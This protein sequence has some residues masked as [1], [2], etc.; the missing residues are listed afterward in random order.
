MKDYP[1][2][3][4]GGAWRR[5]ARAG[6]LTWVMWAWI[7]LGAGTAA[8]GPGP[9]P[10]ADDSSAVFILYGNVFREDGSTPW[11]EADTLIVQNQRTLDENRVALGYPFQGAFTLIFVDLDASA[12]AMVDDDLVFAFMPSYFPLS[13]E[14]VTLDS[15]DV[16][17]GYLELDLR[18]IESASDAGGSVNRLPLRIDVRPNPSAGQPMQLELLFG[19]PRVARGDLT[20]VVQDAT[21]RVVR[22]IHARL[23]GFERVAVPW[24][25]RDAS[26]RAL[27]PGVYWVRVPGTGAG[28]AGRAVLID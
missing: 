7:L 14:V 10:A 23:G 27:A 16:A 12:A 13:P 24:D 15:L 17:Q 8:A 3:R 19:A 20:L 5:I 21:G 11:P 6:T 2:G 18:V 26:G 22:R 4:E 28:A 1:H 9:A 25:G